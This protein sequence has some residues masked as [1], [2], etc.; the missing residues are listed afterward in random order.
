M[1]PLVVIAYNDFP[2]ITIE[3][4]VLGAAGAE[5]RQLGLLTTPEARAAAA[6]AQALMVTIQ[7][8][9]DELLSQLPRLRL[10]SRVGTGLDAID[11]VAATARR[12]QV[13]NVP[14]YSVDEVSTHAIALLLNH[15]RRLPPLL[16][17]TRQGA[18]DSRTVR[19][20][21]RLKE[22]TLGILGFGRIARAVAR[23]ALGLGL[24]VLAYDPYV[25]AAAMQAEGVTASAW[26]TLL[27]VSDFVSLH[28]P[29]TPQTQGILDA[30]ALGLMKP[31]AL[32]IN[33]ARGGLVDEAAL[34]QALDA[35]QIAAAA[36][37]VL[38]TEPPAADHPL[39]SHPRTYITPHIG[40]YSEA[41]NQDVRVRAADEVARMLRGEAPRCPA[42][43]LEP[44]PAA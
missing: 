26:D 8:V 32:L 13:T 18:W 2:D 43:H 4:D 1:S 33:T 19:P 35:G 11:L 34:L 29:L 23:K 3:Q 10:V 6:E 39:L 24:R 7:P 25:D 14:D 28:V 16:A 12:V 36:L 22:Q 40:W 17:A 20:I 38:V 37:D 42:N 5:V 31:A 41:A 27:Q 44:A 9:T 15:A 21:P 30:R